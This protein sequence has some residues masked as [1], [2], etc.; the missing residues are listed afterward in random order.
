MGH[1]LGLFFRGPTI[2]LC[3]LS[4]GRSAEGTFHSKQRNQITSGSFQDLESVGEP[5][6]YSQVGWKRCSLIV[7]DEYPT[8][9]PTSFPYVIFLIFFLYR[10]I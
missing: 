1:C 8:P 6:N 2:R 9:F 10:F 4:N 3:R 5:R 7:L